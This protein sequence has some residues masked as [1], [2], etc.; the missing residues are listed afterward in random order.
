MK[1]VQLET[2]GVPSEVCRSRPQPHRSRTR[3]LAGL[4]M[5]CPAGLCSAGPS[6]PARWRR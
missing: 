2:F 3:S 4:A 1:M 6:G 5:G